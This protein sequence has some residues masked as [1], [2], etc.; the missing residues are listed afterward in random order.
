MNI[1]KDEEKGEKKDDV[2]VVTITAS[3]DTNNYDF[4]ISKRDE[5]RAKEYKMPAALYKLHNS[6]VWTSNIKI[7]FNV[8]ILLISISYIIL[9]A[10]GVFFTSFNIKNTTWGWYMPSSAMTIISSAKIALSAIYKNSVN[11]QISSFKDGKIDSTVTPTFVGEVYIKSSRS[12][13]INIWLT[14]WLNVYILIFIGIVSLLYYK[15]EGIWEI[16]EIGSNFYTKIDWHNILNNTFGSTVV[17]I[18]GF[19][20]FLA[21]I[22]VLAIIKYIY[23]Y[24]KMKLVESYVPNNISSYQEKSNTKQLHKACLIISLVVLAIFIS[25]IV[26]PLFILWKKRKRNG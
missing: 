9:Q 7:I 20:V 25:L 19:S 17:L 21:V 22:T 4:D 16:G 26:I 6:E 15:N 10:I 5:L 2:K 23:N 8:I 14:T 24:K 12:N 1:Y 3:Q 18:V 11:N 13:I